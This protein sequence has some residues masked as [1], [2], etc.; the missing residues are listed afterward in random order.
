MIVSKRGLAHLRRHR[1]HCTG[2][3]ARTCLSWTT[4]PTVVLGETLRQSRTPIR[5]KTADTLGTCKLYDILLYCTYINCHK[6]ATI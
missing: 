6:S 4:P 2:T 5:T 3:W 1:N